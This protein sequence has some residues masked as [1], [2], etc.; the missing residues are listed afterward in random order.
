MKQNKVEIVSVS[1]DSKQAQ[2]RIFNNEGRGVTRHV[3]YDE[4][5][6]LWFAIIGYERKNNDDNGWR[7]D[8]KK[9]VPIK[10][11]YVIDTEIKAYIIANPPK[12]N[13]ISRKKNRKTVAV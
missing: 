9:K 1:K 12:S 13:K 10:K 8:T 2:I 3:K 4:K 7:G 5:R 6:K 11:A